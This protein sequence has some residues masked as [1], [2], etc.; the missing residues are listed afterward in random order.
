[1]SVE[2][3]GQ[4]IRVMVNLAN[5]QQEEPTGCGGGRQ[6]SMDDTSR[7]TGDSHARF[8]E[9]LGVKFLGADSGVGSDAHSYGDP[10]RSFEG[11]NGK[12]RRQRRGRPQPSSEMEL[13]AGQENGLD[14]G[15]HFKLPT[16]TPFLCIQFEWLRSANLNERVALPCQTVSVV[17]PDEFNRAYG[18][19]SDSSDLCR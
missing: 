16:L 3:R 10:G 12:G 18:T 13:I 1:M 9:R 14:N 17:R 5:W 6:L 8:C 2:R 15:V 7:V 19:E 4:A 11:R